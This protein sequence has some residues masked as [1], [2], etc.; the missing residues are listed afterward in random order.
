MRFKV[1]AVSAKQG[2]L[3]RSSLRFEPRT[4]RLQRW[5][6][7]FPSQVLRCLLECPE[8]VMVYKVKKFKCEGLVGC[9]PYCL[10]NKRPSQPL[11]RHVDCKP[12]V[13]KPNGLMLLRYIPHHPC[14]MSPS[15][16]FCLFSHR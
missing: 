13:T 10:S 6:I 16:P 2:Q 7:D 14:C 8:Q 3:S 5:T 11:H 12:N 1:K 9:L 4:N 15:S